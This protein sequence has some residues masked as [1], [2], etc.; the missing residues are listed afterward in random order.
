[1]AHATAHRI[2]ASEQA[3]RGGEIPGANR[4]TNPAAADT[5]TTA[6]DRINHI[7]F[8][9]EARR[10][11]HAPLRIGRTVAAETE[12]VPDHDDPRPR[13]LQMLHELLGRLRPQRLGEVQ[14]A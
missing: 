11:F 8:Q 5:L 1:M 2:G 4:G 12:V 14:Q 13:G 10:I 7:E 6:L 9:S 3:L